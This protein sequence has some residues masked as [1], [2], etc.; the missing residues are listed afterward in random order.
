MVLNHRHSGPLPLAPI[1]MR[2]KRTCSPWL[3]VFSNLPISSTE[4]ATPS[5]GLEFASYGATTDAKA[6]LEGTV[7]GWN[8]SQKA[9]DAR[10]QVRRVHA[11]V[12]P[13]NLTP[14]A[15]QWT[16][17]SSQ[18]STLALGR[19]QHL[20]TVSS[21]LIVQPAGHYDLARRGLPS[22]RLGRCHVLWPVARATSR[23]IFRTA[24]LR[25]SC[26]SREFSW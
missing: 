11:T 20:I 2:F 7:F 26:E 24:T 4:P 21:P 23:R 13:N 14:R 16:S 15:G 19:A 6:T 17:R 25:H 10:P 12:L 1:V 9:S 18:G 3:K 22:V 5:S 8:S